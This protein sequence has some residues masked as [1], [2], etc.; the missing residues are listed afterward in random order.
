[1]TTKT[2]H[3]LSDLSPENLTLLTNYISEQ[4]AAG[5]CDGIQTNVVRVGVSGNLIERNWT[6]VEAA[7]AFVAFRNNINPPPTYAVVVS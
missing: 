3:S 1:M 5:N 6:T 2:L 7:T 4:M